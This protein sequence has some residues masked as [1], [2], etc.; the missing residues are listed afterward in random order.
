MERVQLLI[1]RAPLIT[2]TRGHNFHGRM[3]IAVSPTMSRNA[4]KSPEIPA[5]IEP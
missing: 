3:T 2:A 1:E 4:L 5:K